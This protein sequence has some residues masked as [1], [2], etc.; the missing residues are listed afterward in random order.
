MPRRWY[1]STCH[2]GLH[3]Q[4]AGARNLRSRRRGGRLRAA[5]A[6][7]VGHSGQSGL[8]QQFARCSLWHET[9]TS[10][11]QHHGQA[12]EEAGP[13]AR[14]C[15][16]TPSQATA[17]ACRRPRRTS[18]RLLSQLRRSSEPLRRKRTCA[19]SKTFRKITSPSSPSTPSTATGVRT[20]KRR[21]CAGSPTLCPARPSAIARW[22][23]R[24]GSIM[25]WATPSRRSSMSRSS[26]TSLAHPRRPDPD[27]VPAP[28]GPLRLVSADPTDALD[29][30]VLHADETGWRVTARPTGSGALRRPD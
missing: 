5:R 3:Y 16:N 1:H 30:A 10:Q 29:S 6:H 15:G 13:Q 27:V 12:K 25:G 9:D 24:P 7:Q 26:T 17:R 18:G 23:S 19:I 14:A 4:A 8:R 2:W 11:A 22:C 21:P 28:G 20:V